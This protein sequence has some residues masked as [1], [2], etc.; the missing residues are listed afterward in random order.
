MQEKELLQHLVD[1]SESLSEILRKQNKAVSGSSIKILKEKLE[2]YGIQY[3][4]LNYNHANKNKISLQDKLQEGTNIN[5]NS[6]KNLLI[7]PL[8]IGTA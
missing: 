4:F 8:I 5:S 3:H 6:L 2:T 7:S 1:T